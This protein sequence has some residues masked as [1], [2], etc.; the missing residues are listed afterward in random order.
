MQKILCDVKSV[1]GDSD[2]VSC[3][4]NQIVSLCQRLMQVSSKLKLNI[5]HTRATHTA[6]TRKNDNSDSESEDTSNSSRATTPQHI[7]AEIGHTVTT[8]EDTYLTPRK[9]DGTNSLFSI[10][11]TQ[12]QNTGV[13]NGPTI[14]RLT[15]VNLFSS[16]SDSPEDKAR[17]CASESRSRSP[18]RKVPILRRMRTNSLSYENFRCPGA[19]SLTSHDNRSVQSDGKARQR[20]SS[21]PSLPS[22]PFSGDIPQLQFLERFIQRI[23]NKART[24]QSYV[25]ESNTEHDRWRTNCHAVNDPCT[26][27]LNY[28]EGSM[29]VVL[30]QDEISRATLHPHF[31]EKDSSQ[32][33]HMCRYKGRINSHQVNNLVH[34]NGAQSLNTNQVLREN[35]S[36]SQ[37]PST[38]NELRQWSN[39]S[40]SSSRSVQ[41]RILPALPKSRD[42]PTDEAYSEHS[43]HTLRNRHTITP[44]LDPRREV[45]ACNS[46]P[47]FP[48]G[49][50][51]RS[52]ERD[53]SFFTWL[54]RQDMLRMERENE[55]LDEDELQFK[56]SVRTAKADIIDKLKRLPFTDTENEGLQS[57]KVPSYRDFENKIDARSSPCAIKLDNNYVNSTSDNHSNVQTNFI[58]RDNRTV[59][60]N[61][62]CL[63]TLRVSPF[64]Q[65]NLKNSELNLPLHSNNER[66]FDMN[67]IT[68]SSSDA[69]SIVAS[70]IKKFESEIFKNKS[71]ANSLDK[72]SRRTSSSTGQ[73]LGSRFRSS[74]EPRAHSART[75]VLSKRK[76]DV[77]TQPRPHQPNKEYCS[78]N[79]SATSMKQRMVQESLNS[80][81]LLRK[82]STENDLHHLVTTE[83]SSSIREWSLR[84]STSF[85]RKQSEQKPV[86][87]Y[88]YMFAFSFSVP[89]RMKR[90]HVSAIAVLDN[91]N[92]VVLDERNFYL[93]LFDETL[94]QVFERKLYDIPRGCERVNNNNVIVAL[95]YKRTLHHYSIIHKSINLEKET[96]LNC[97][98]WILDIAFSNDCL[99][100]LCKGGHVH[101]MTQDGIEVSCVSIGMNGRLFCHPSRKRL[102]ILG[103]GRLSK[104]DMEGKLITSHS[105]ID[106]HS[107][108]FLEN[109]TYIADREK[110]RIVPL[111][112]VIDVQE[113]TADKIEYPSATCTSI[114]SDKL[115]VSQYEECL[116]DATTRTIRVYE[117]SKH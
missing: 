106:A 4:A 84:R 96:S 115:F 77:P 36:S 90:C 52:L 76:P 82:S 54:K 60:S 65:N 24:D 3:F 110:H 94:N 108:L 72:R 28:N 27:S 16:D 45:N 51:I 7:Y 11:G 48:S 104:F 66:Q 111:T 15:G 86:L 83:S 64:I 67:S 87:A 73:K 6:E 100:I 88:K 10:N 71:S 35:V 116:D 91:D 47:P 43:A 78:R 75:S 23:P 14:P 42:N 109:Q 39:L 21:Q 38:Q 58:Q 49:I 98:A 34:E 8:G 102:Y 69:N 97:N 33:S 70:N 50:H 46:K 17:V 44:S 62:T 18:R 29:R 112:D 26:S 37:S 30:H 12:N 40:P 93:H 114:T 5:K 59:K 9:T 19:T 80:R 1:D 81:H 53:R 113:L 57:E 101:R 25:Q 61:N 117:L 56:E 95:P 107:I 99:N 32:L 68:S 105:D 31:V 41:K 22:V 63:K 20:S 92:V 74:S 85:T 13:V 89:E 55:D 2:I 79:N 103:E